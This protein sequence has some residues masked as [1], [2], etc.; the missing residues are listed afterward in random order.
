VA[1]DA[2]AAFAMTPDTDQSLRVKKFLESSPETSIRARLAGCEP[3]TMS[4]FGTMNIVAVSTA[5]EPD[6]RRSLD[7]LSCATS[8][9]ANGR[10]SSTYF[11]FLPLS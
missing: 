11:V 9:S 4:S 10:V 6:F 3:H 8:S 5:R 7:Q 2:L 1:T